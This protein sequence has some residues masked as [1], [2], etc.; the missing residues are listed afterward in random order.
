[1]S[2]VFRIYLKCP[3]NYDILIMQKSLRRILWNGRMSAQQHIVVFQSNN[4][5]LCICFSSHKSI[6]NG[7]SIL[8][9]TTIFEALVR[10]CIPDGLKNGA[11]SITRASNFISWIAKYQ[12]IQPQ[13]LMGPTSKRQPK[14]FFLLFLIQL[15][16][17]ISLPY[18]FDTIVGLGP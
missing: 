4:A 17:A 12:A 15:K 16:K 8:H 13:K 6:P 7:G 3:Y 5:M 18:L 9:E 2:C 1:M 14:P 11:T 10:N